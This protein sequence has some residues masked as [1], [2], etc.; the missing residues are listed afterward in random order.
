MPLGGNKEWLTVT[1]KDSSCSNILSSLVLMEI[2]AAVV[3][4]LNVTVLG[5]AE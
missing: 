2:E 1:W 5:E 3:P 4:A